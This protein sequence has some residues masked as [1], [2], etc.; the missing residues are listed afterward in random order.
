[1]LFN[2]RIRKDGRRTGARSFSPTVQIRCFTDSPISRD[3]AL[4]RRC[5]LRADSPAEIPQFFPDGASLYDLKTD[6]GETRNLVGQGLPAER[7]LADLLARWE[8]DRRLRPAQA[9]PSGL[10]PEEEQRMQ[11]LGYAAAG[12][13]PS[14]APP[15]AAKPA[16]SA[17]PS[18]SAKPPR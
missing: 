6:P 10:S 3:W 4:E 15:A 5:D 18:P 12:K 17:K 1:V 13:A 14:A 7:E 11:A 2:G 16:P 8:T 9:Q